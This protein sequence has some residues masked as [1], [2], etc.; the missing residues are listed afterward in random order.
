MIVHN[1]PETAVQLIIKFEGFYS[2]PYKCP[3]GCW[4]IG[5]GHRLENKDGTFVSNEASMQDLKI[6]SI[7]KEAALEILQ[8]KLE[9]TYLPRIYK[10]I[11]SILNVNQLSALLSLVYNVGNIGKELGEA[12]N[13]DPCDFD[14]IESKWLKYCNINKDGQ[15][16]KLNGLLI[17]RKAE[18][19][20]Y[21]SLM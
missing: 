19:G 21:K 14:V 10:T 11:T 7:T 17:R 13:N 16:V 3:A 8:I 1:V 9:H 5:Y 12:I 2:T 15:Y 18:F 6:Q 4:T 20:I